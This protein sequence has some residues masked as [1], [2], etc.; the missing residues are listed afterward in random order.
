MAA[1][2]RM[3]T[4]SGRELGRILIA[5]VA[6]WLVAAASPAP[7]QDHTEYDPADIVYGRSVYERECTACHAEDGAGVA[8]VNL[9]SGPLR[10]ASSDRQLS[11]L[12]SNGIPDTG[13]LAF[14]LDTSEMAGIIAYVRNMN[15]EGD[16]VELGDPARGQAVFEGAG[17]C[18]QCHRLSGEGSRAGV[19][20]TSIGARR[21]PSAL[22]R[23]LLDPTGTMRPI[24][25]PVTLVTADGTTVTGRRLNEDT[26]T[27]QII[28]A[29]GRLRSFDKSDLRRFDV[30]VESPMPAYGDRL[31]PE[32]LADLLAYLV[33]LKG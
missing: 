11:Q 4:M 29:D 30:A 10:R 31:A 33:S 16:E 12:I 1:E 24:D 22:R 23:T 18:L 15:Y 27:V 8:G 13:M 2:A 25:R 14:D 3:K 21:P 28:D 17:D 26:Y 5:G 32:E 19:D 9:R 20:L 7:A 6:V